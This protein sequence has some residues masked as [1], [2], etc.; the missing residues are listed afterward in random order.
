VATSAVET[1]MPRQVSVRGLG[2]SRTLDLVDGRARPPEEH[3][4]LNDA[5]ARL[6]GRAETTR[7]PAPL[8]DADPI[9]TARAVRRALAAAGRKAVEVDALCV[10]APL[11]PTAEACRRLARRA[12]GPHGSEI[13]AFGVAVASEHAEDLAMAAAAYLEAAD[14]SNEVS[15]AEGWALAVCVGVAADG[16]SVALCLGR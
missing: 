10:A 6:I 14:T 15:V 1:H 5:Q 12:L 9:E 11:A 2:G 13:A 8:D 16:T 3:A 4:R 7:G